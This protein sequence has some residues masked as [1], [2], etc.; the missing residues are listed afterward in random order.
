MNIGPF[1]TRFIEDLPQ[2]VSEVLAEIILVENGSKDHTLSVCNELKDQYPDLIRVLSLER[3]SYGEAIKR[4]ML[5]SRGTHLS[6]L[7][8]DF[9]D[10]DFIAKSIELFK[11]ES[12]NFIVASKRH[13]DAVDD[14]PLKRRLLTLG[15]NLFLTAFFRYPGTDTHG[16][17]SI[18]SELAKKLCAL[19]ETTDEIFQTE[20][21][22]MAWKLGEKITEL[23]I[24]VK[25][26]RPVVVSI[27]RRVPKVMNIVVALHKS[28]KRFQ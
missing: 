25:E 4:G 16:L 18:Q 17:K 9:L 20:I 15:F 23:P 26:E 3:G 13:P 14:R 22:L 2:T 19:A 11:T 5:E 28:L 12:S 27:S 24:R 21:V 6:I 10:A 8:C 1:V 7:E